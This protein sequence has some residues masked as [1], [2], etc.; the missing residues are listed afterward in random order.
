MK[1]T[2]LASCLLAACSQAPSESVAENASEL[3][4]THNILVIELYQSGAS[5][6]WPQF[7]PNGAFANDVKRLSYANSGF[8]DLG[9]IKPQFT[10]LSPI[11]TTPSLIG[12]DGVSDQRKGMQY[13]I[14]QALSQGVNLSSYK[15]IWLVPDNQRSLL[16]GCGT[17]YNTSGARLVSYAGLPAGIGGIWGATPD[18]GGPVP[19]HEFEHGLGPDGTV[20]HLYRIDCSATP[21]VFI[22]SANCVVTQNAPD[23]VAE[24]LNALGGNP[25]NWDPFFN[26]NA[27]YKRR[28]GWIPPGRVAEFA[29]GQTGDVTIVD[30][31]NALPG[32]GFLMAR[33]TRPDGRVFVFDRR[34]RWMTGSGGTTNNPGVTVYLVEADGV[35][36]VLAAPSTLIGAAS[37]WGRLRSWPT[38]FQVQVEPGFQV[39]TGTSTSPQLLQILQNQ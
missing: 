28:W 21:G 34:S 27:E 35:P 13:G 33:V 6:T 8:S 7:S 14:N 18:Q 10:V 5:V 1:K 39:R 25:A 4:S 38:N 23:G 29:A 11:G 31:D 12:C 22:N 26:E 2:L 3:S 17:L 20:S 32:Q 15:H 16:P 37:Y 24:A 36:K 19:V 9:G 30:S